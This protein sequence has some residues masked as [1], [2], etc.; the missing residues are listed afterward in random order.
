MEHIRLEKYIPV[1]KRYDV[2]VCGGG[3]AGVAAAVSAA[4]NGLSTLLLE[5]SNILGGLGTL[6]L[7]NLFVPMCN[8]RGKQIIFGL[9]EKWLRKSTELGINT[10]PN[11]WKN[12]E[13]THPTNERYW[14]RYSPAIFAY[15]LTEE[16]MHSGA[17][18]LFDCMAVDPV[19][20]GNICKGVITESK[21]GT[22]FYGCR[23]LI[24]TT[25]DCDVLRRGGVPTVEGENF[26]TFSTKMITLDSCR[27][28]YEKGDIRFAYRDLYAGEANLYGDG[29]PSDIPRWSGLSAGDVTDYILRNHKIMLDKLRATDRKGR[30]IVTTPGMPQFRTTCHIKGDYSLRVADA[31]RHFDDSVCAINDF[32]HRDHLF[33]VPLRCLTRHD[34]PNIITAGRSADGTGYGW[35]VLRV[36]PPAILTGQ[37]A[38]EA[39]YLALKSDRPVAGV[40]IKSLQAKMEREN[41]MV[42]F[43]DE[44]VPEDRTVIIHGKNAAEIPGGHI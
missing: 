30:E 34:Y 9:A 37:A 21:G 39:A 36:S 24:D 13:P 20:E 42:H 38:G 2:I 43:P 22:E 35:D 27:E 5:K 10:I 32:D 14:Q 31:Y 16:I 26:F 19:M 15:Q 33:E 41:V 18:I 28:A 3:V 6:G 25:G 17:D 1:K 40:D 8:G 29:Q 4:K 23:I 44:Y 7:I 12:G 11:A